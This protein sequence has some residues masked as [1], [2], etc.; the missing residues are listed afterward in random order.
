MPI[1]LAVTADG[2]I[3][4]TDYNK[5]CLQFLD[6][7]F[8]LKQKVK[9]RYKPEYV[10]AL[11]NGDLLVT[12]DGHLIHVL[13]KHGRRGARIFHVTGALAKV[14]TTKGIAVDGL[15]RIVVTI[16]YQVFVLSPIG[17]VILKFGDK[18]QGQQQFDSFLR[19]AVNSRNQIIVSDCSNGNLKIFNPAGLHLFTCGSL[20]S[21]P[22]QLYR[23]YSVIT[24]SEDNIILADCYNRRVSVFS[25]DGTFIRHLL[26]K[27]GHGLN[28]P[29][30]LTLTD[31]L[32][33]VVSENKS[34]KMFHL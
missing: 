26:T 3:V 23:P 34:I 15:G 7:D 30:G 31:D 21:G 18:G 14:E 20:G 27:E 29:T 6:K 1:S 9:L 8:S 28:S 10:A 33:L 16:G 32:D 11:T 25:R 4:V 13:D 2:D 24:D 5:R 22:G 19:V 17:D 12:G